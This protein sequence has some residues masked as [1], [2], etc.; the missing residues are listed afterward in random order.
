MIR[1]AVL[2]TCYNRR[3]VTLNCIQAILQSKLYNCQVDIFIVD[4][5][6][7]DGT[8]SAIS[9]K[10][11]EINI[12]VISGLYWN[13]GMIAAWNEA[14]NTEVSYDAFLL[15]ND[16]VIIQENSLS[17]LVDIMNIWKGSKVVVGFTTSPTTGKVSYG[18]LKRQSGLSRIRFT[19][20]SDNNDEIVTMNGN[21]VLVPRMVFEEIGMLNSRFQHSF[22]DI[23]YG[24]RVSKAGFGIILSRNPVAVM[25]ANETA[26]SR[27]QK[28]GFTEVFLLMKTPKGLP[29]EE[30]WYFCRQHAGVFWLINFFVRYLRMTRL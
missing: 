20:T 25:E 22:G 27:S 5:G 3:K 13:R 1:I 9:E 30:W 19:L 15:I 24:L 18:G 29:I 2:I 6:S 16:D 4:G 21:C 23:D 8:V 17:E 12:K 11:P 26:Y 10:H 7:T 14:V 28:L